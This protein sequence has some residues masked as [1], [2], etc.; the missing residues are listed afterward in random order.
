M[1]AITSARWCSNET[2]TSQMLFHTSEFDNDR[3]HRLGAGELVRT[4]LAVRHFMV[5]RIPQAG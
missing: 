5:T 3:N 1:N 2:S 4:K